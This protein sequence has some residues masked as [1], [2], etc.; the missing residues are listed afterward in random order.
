[1]TDLKGLWADGRRRGDA[2]G[3]VQHHPRQ[4]VREV[5]KRCHD[6]HVEPEKKRATD[7]LTFVELRENKEDLTELEAWSAKVRGIGSVLRR[8]SRLVR[9]SE[10]DKANVESWQGAAQRLKEETYTLYLA[11]R[12]PRVIWYARIFVALLVGYVFSPV[13]PIP[14]FIL[15]VGLLDEMV[16]VPLGVIL[17]RKMIPGEVLAEYRKRSQEVMKEGKKPVSHAAA[18][19]V[20]AVWL[21]LAALSVF[22]T[23]PVAQ[24]LGT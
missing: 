10:V 6:L 9:A 11:Y 12:D 20:V 24:G 3:G 21:L 16:V 14:D 22:L 8:R 17:A 23:F 15:V 4:R 1:V 2:R 18:V 19:V 7:K 5:F 13:D